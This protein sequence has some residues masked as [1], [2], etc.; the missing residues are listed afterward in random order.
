MHYKLVENLGIEVF[1]NNDVPSGI[2]T[3]QEL[4]QK[5]LRT[6]ARE[7]QLL[8]FRDLQEHILHLNSQPVWTVKPQRHYGEKLLEVIFSTIDHPEPQQMWRM[9]NKQVLAPKHH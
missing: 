7:E 4:F 8:L 6:R 5:V 3:Q 2:L 1:A 9:L